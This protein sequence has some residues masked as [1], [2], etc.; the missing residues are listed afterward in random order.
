MEMCVTLNNK[1]IIKFLFAFTSLTILASFQSPAQVKPP[2]V[3]LIVADDL[4]YS[5]LASYGN[6]HIQTPN[7]DALGKDGFRFTQ[8]YVSAP[9]CGPSREGIFTGRYQQ[10]F[11]D[12]FMP[13]ENLDPAVM[14]NLRRHYGS[15]KKVNTVLENLKPDLLVN[16]KNFNDGLPATEIT[17]AQLLKQKGYTTGLIGKWNLGI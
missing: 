7:I 16:R 2:N 5:D 13:Y 8:A 9:I 1:W 12:E 15:L 11:G 10:R 14:K 4:G 17:I 3:I 6:T